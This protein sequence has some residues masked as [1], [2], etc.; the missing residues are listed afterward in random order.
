MTPKSAQGTVVRRL[1]ASAIV[2]L[3]LLLLYIIG[4]LLSF[5]QT[6]RQLDSPLIP[7]STIEMVNRQYIFHAAVSS[8]MLVVAVGIYLLKQYWWAILLVA[9]TLVANRYIY[10]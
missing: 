3:A 5:Y 8:I 2:C 10:W 1:K 4:Q 6:G 7:K 9:I